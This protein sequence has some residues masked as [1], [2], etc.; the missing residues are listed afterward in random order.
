MAPA[1]LIS[2]GGGDRFCSFNRQQYPGSLSQDMGV[3]WLIITGGPS[4]VICA[5]VRDLLKK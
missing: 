2:L 5:I 1:D 3:T 4:S